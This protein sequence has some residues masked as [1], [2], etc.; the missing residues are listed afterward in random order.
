M[1]TA[2]LTALFGW[3]SLL[4]IGVFTLASLMVVF[5]RDTLMGM[6][7]RMFGID[8]ADLQRMYFWYL[9]LYKIAILV[10]CLGPYVALR[11]IG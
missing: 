10:V 8:R 3:M 4:N 2:D 11:I 5:S 9:A 7:E 1:T 6:H